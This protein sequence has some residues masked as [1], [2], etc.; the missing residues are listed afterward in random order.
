MEKFVNSLVLEKVDNLVDYIK[1]SQEYKDY[2]FL[3]EKL[4]NNEKVSVMIN[5]IKKLQK[6]IV[7]REVNNEDIKDLDQEINI[8][9][10]KLN[11]I[12]LYVEFTNKQMELNEIYQTIK[13]RLDEYFYRILN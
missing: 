5:K 7:K 12:P 11:R 10:D 13:S 3:S 9:L 8:L 6:E 4:S 2:L 1:N